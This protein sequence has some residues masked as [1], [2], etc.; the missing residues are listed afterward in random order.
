MTLRWLSFRSP[1]QI[2]RACLPGCMSVTAAVLQIPLNNGTTQDMLEH[3]QSCRVVTAVLQV[4]CRRAPGTCWS[5][6]K[7]AML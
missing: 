2:A 6:V 4:P 5:T 1:S 3:C 7:A